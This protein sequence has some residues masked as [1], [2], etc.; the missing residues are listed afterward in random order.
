MIVV[1]IGVTGSGKSTIGSMLAR[2]M[3]CEFLEGDT[4]HSS[5]NIEKMTRGIP[6]SDDDR[7]P[8][9]SAI[10]ARIADASTRGVSLVVACSALKHAYRDVLERGVAI[11]WVY[12]KGSKELLRRRLQERTSHFMKADM[13]DGQFEALEEPSNAMVID[14]AAPPHAIAERIVWQLSLGVDVRVLADGE[15]LSAEAAAAAVDIINGAVATRGRC[16]LALSGGDTPRGLYRL[17]GSQYRDRVPWRRVHVFWGDDRYVPG[18][19]PDS[20]YRLARETLLDHVPCRAENIHAMPTHFSSAAEAAATYD[21]V[22]KDHFGGGDGPAFDLNILGIGEDAH[23]ASV[24]PGS[25]AV[26]E[27][28]RWVMDVHTDATIATRLTLTLP[29]LSH[30][31]NIYVLVGGSDKALAIQHALAPD[32]DPHVYP[33]AGIPRRWGVVWWVDRAAARGLAPQQRTQ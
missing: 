16:S 8:W 5:A 7:G 11:S 1:V 10:H 25:P 29:A 14:V 22:L 32:S 4:L 2:A 20:N 18:D 13:L 17:L 21:E 19:H 27:R 23:T 3:G 12:L 26:D 6:L 15:V 33:A 9:L 31:I 28:E 24:F 30:S